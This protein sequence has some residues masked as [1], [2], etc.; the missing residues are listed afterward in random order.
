MS[1]CTYF[2]A[3]QIAEAL[4][5]DCCSEFPHVQAYS[6]P[7][8]LRADL[9]SEAGTGWWRR[10]M[11]ALAAGGKSHRSLFSGPVPD[12]PTGCNC[13]PSL[14]DS[15]ALQQQPSP[16]WRAGTPH[17]VSDGHTEINSKKLRI[18]QEITSPLSIQSI[19]DETFWRV[20]L[21]S[22]I[23]A[24]VFGLSYSCIKRLS[25]P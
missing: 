1:W 21:R 8:V 11:G 24:I 14:A 3:E 20:Y 15:A 13:C 12:C 9:L 19:T 4:V 25:P 7:C 23:Q 2:N 16:G 10:G 5:W 17:T 22:Q 6:L 18:L